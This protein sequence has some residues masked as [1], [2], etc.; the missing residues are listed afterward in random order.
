MTT[1][2]MKAVTDGISEHE[3][4]QGGFCPGGGGGGG[5]F[6]LG[7]YCL[8]DIVQGDIDLEP[9]IYIYVSIY[10]QEPREEL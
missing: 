8:G 7:G 10:C 3:A 6:V 4:H 1:V 2:D 9:Y 5:E